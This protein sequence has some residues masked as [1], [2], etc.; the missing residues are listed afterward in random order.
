[1]T[2]STSSST[3]ALQHLVLGVVG[4]GLGDAEMAELPLRLLLQEGGCDHL[5]RLLISLG[6]H[7]VQ[8]E[9]VDVVGTEPAQR[10]WRLVTARAA[11]RRPSP[12]PDPRLGGDEDSVAGCS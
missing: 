11:A 8:L 10:A 9:D 2:T 6:C 12:C 5:A 4:G 1:M 7:T 3:G